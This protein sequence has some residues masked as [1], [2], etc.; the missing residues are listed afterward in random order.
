MSRGAKSKVG[1]HTQLADHAIQGVVL[2]EVILEGQDVD[3]HGE[4]ILDGDALTVSEDHTAET[5]GS[6]VL[7]TGDIHLQAVLEL[8]KDG[9]E[10]IDNSSVVRV[11]DQTSDSVSGVGLGLRVL[12]AEAVNQ[13]LEEGRGE[14]GHRGAHAVDALGQDTNSGG[15]LKRL[16]AAGIAEDGLLEDLPELSEARAQGSGH[17]RD[18]VKR[19]VDNNPVELRGLLGSHLVLTELNLARV[20][21]VDNVGNHLDDIVKGGLVGNESRAAEAQVLSHVAVDISNGS[22][23]WKDG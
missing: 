7:Q 15:T 17:T 3:Q 19:R 16:A 23:R 9:G 13:E 11:L 4:N 5:S 22:P 12:I 18:N 10:L 14:L 6:V 1:K 21:L 8:A 20:L 2:L